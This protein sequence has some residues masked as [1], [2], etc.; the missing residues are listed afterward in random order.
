MAS[1][2]E[3]VAFDPELPEADRLVM[4]NDARSLHPAS[5][6][7]PGRP[8][9]GGRVA[10]DVW[11][12]LLTATVWGYLPAVIG[13]FAG[14]AARGAPG[15]ALRFAG[16]LLQAALV[17]CWIGY[18]FTAMFLAGAAV[19]AVAFVTYL[20]L[21]GESRAS[22]LGRR[23]HG[24]YLVSADFDPLY[25]ALMQRTQAAVGEVLGSRVNEAG[26]LDEI[27]NRV[28]LPRQ[29]WE[30]AQALAEMTRLSREQ[31]RAREGKVTPRI[32]AVLDSQR[33]ALR[34]AA[35]SIRERVAALEDYALRTMAADEAYQEWRIL[36][37]LAD[38]GDD[39][40]ELLARTVRDRLAA[41]EV[42]ELTGRARQ[43][44]EALCESVAEARRAG[45]VLLPAG[46]RP[47]D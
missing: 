19:Q 30:I 2:S 3:C 43:V 13:P 34:V 31:R 35:D 4:R 41:G 29:E 10:G 40:R 22:V 18:G 44:D 1:S 36:Q 8:P 7:P 45:M 17:A 5:S 28:T 25:L 20:G 15:R 38:D 12:S 32:E 42:G 11:T 14:A 47:V 24:R 37:D 23:H 39:Y 27:A 9:W 6:P 46:A 33:D 26:L 21:G 16:W